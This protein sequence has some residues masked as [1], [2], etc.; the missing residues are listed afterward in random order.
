MTLTILF[1]PFSP[2]LVFKFQVYLSS[3]QRHKIAIPR[4]LSWE[5][6]KKSLP[7]NICN[8]HVL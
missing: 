4:P 1:E 8:S 2:T 5:Y 7:I 3:T 6:L